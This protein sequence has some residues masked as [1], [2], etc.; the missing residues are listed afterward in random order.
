M[1]AG[2]APTFKRFAH[3][4]F[5][6]ALLLTPALSQSGPLHEGR[7]SLGP[8]HLASRAAWLAR[9]EAAKARYEAF[10]TRA[11]LAVHPRVIEPGVP[12]PQPTAGTAA[13]VFDDPTLRPGDV[14][15]T[16]EGLRV[17]RGAP[18]ASH[19]PGDFVPVAAAKTRHAPELIELQRALELGKR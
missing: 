13:S 2:V 17:F 18:G 19:L 5:A 16:S 11:R 4:I 10:A 7:S 15:V 12:P 6:Q 14:V 9:V 8:S 3:A 1:R